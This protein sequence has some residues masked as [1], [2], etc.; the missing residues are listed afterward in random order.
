M[1]HNAGILTVRTPSTVP[2]TNIPDRLTPAILRRLAS[3]SVT[4]Q[5]IRFLANKQ[6]Q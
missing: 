3:R 6:F 5:Q 1:T 2:L 4:T